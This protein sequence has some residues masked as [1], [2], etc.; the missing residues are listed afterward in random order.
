LSEIE[1]HIAKSLELSKLMSQNTNQTINIMCIDRNKKLSES[2]RNDEQSRPINGFNQEKCSNN[3][4]SVQNKMVLDCLLQCNKIG[5]NI[6]SI[7][8]LLL[9]TYI[10]N[11][12]FSEKL[13]NGN[14]NGDIKSLP[15]I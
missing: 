12:D 11:E 15:D 10:A 3:F 7:N 1:F 9:A 14:I 13:A 4:F 8:E 5:A 6:H 2:D